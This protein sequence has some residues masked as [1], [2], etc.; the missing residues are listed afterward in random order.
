M[1]HRCNVVVK[2]WAWFH[3]RECV[4]CLLALPLLHSNLYSV[5][6]SPT[7]S[8]GDMLRY[9]PLRYLISLKT[10]FCSV[11]TAWSEKRDIHFKLESKKHLMLI[12]SSCVLYTRRH[13]AM[14]NCVFG[15]PHRTQ[16]PT[17]GFFVSSCVS[18]HTASATPF[19]TFY[20]NIDNTVGGGRT[21]AGFRVRNIFP[22]NQLSA[23]L[24]WY[25][26]IGADIL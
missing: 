26:G 11:Q 2:P 6:S 13:A 23:S 16:K 3:V 7:I 10:Y 20:P 18:L 1:F 24:F 5:S 4:F 8:L 21:G 15:R 12:H 17:F 14:R 22:H 25:N 9:L 19:H